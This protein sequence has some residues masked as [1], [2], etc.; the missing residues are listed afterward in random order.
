MWG[1]FN[2]RD[3]YSPKID[4]QINSNK[5]VGN[6]LYKKKWCLLL[7]CTV[8]FIYQL[9]EHKQQYHLNCYK[10]RTYYIELLFSIF[11]R[12]GNYGSVRLHAQGHIVGIW[13][14]QEQQLF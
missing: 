3:Y 6:Y 5:T 11:Y 13:Q 10:R 14:K 7:D 1:T 12:W 8:C 9:V 4:K 2:I